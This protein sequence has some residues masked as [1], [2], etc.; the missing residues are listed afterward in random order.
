MWV[1]KHRVSIMVW[2]FFSIL[3]KRERIKREGE[4]K[5]GSKDERG[6]YS[7]RDE[8]G[9]LDT[10]RLDSLEEVDH[11]FGLESLQLRMETDERPRPSNS[12][13]E[14]RQFSS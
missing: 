5:K 11:T 6:T 9:S 4:K 14:E 7:V 12:V 1:Q 3:C 10:S 8:A 13:T 2:S